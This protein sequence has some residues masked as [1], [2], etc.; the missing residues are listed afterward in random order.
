MRPFRTLLLPTALL[1]PICIWWSAGFIFDR[2][3][4][5][6]IG[7]GPSLFFDVRIPQPG[8]F[9]EKELLSKDIYALSNPFKYSSTIFMFSLRR[10]FPIDRLSW[11]DK[12]DAV[13][14]QI[15]ESFGRT[16]VTRA[17]V[18]ASGGIS[19]S[20]ALLSY[21]N[22]MLHPGTPNEERRE[23]CQVIDTLL[24]LKAA[25]AGDKMYSILFHQ[26]FDDTWLGWASEREG[27][28]LLRDW[29]ASDVY[30]HLIYR[31]KPQ[32]DTV[33]RRIRLTVQLSPP[34]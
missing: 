27:D 25:N 8:E 33:E 3:P 13:I 5:Q 7:Y 2:K 17:E 16:S 4:T 30:Q 18:F 20:L 28:A 26:I 14:C 10:Q 15:H 21:L 23:F 11:G 19:A 22:V 1:A 12:S 6:K 32:T 34:S 24:D 29:H 9:S 31:T